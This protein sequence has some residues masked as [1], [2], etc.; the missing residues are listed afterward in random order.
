MARPRI[1]KDREPEHHRGNS[2]RY[3]LRPSQS[4]LVKFPPSYDRADL[5]LVEPPFTAPQ[6]SDGSMID[7][8]I[9]QRFIDAQNPVYNRICAELRNGRKRS[10]WMWFAFPQIAGLGSS[11]WAREFAI[12]SLAEA[13]AYLAHPILGPRLAE[14]TGLV[15]VIE[16][17]SVDQ[18]FGYPDN[19][20]FR[21]SMTLFARATPDNEGFS[22]ALQKYFKGKPDPVTL[23][24]LQAL[25]ANGKR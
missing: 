18:I 4:L 6:P 10:H 16:G 13:A 17:R 7:P 1:A 12:S 19:L 24:S 15:N 3:P 14:S 20:K 23:A 22:A 25:E 2:G 8:Y 5:P 9:L 21:S 11:Q